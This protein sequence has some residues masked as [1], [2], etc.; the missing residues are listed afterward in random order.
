[1]RILV[2]C[3]ILLSMPSVLWATEK[4]HLLGGSF[5]FQ[6]V[7][8]YGPNY[9]SQNISDLAL[10]VEYSQ[11]SNS[12]V[13]YSARLGTQVSGDF[14]SM[15]LGVNYHFNP[16]RWDVNHPLDN[17]SIVTVSSWSPYLGVELSMSRLQISLKKTVSN[18]TDVVIAAQV[19][20]TL[21]GGVYYALSGD[22][23]IKGELQSSYLFSGEVASNSL[24][25]LCGISYF[26]KH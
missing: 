21:K 3:F 25:L 12:F 24:G 19:G 2:W 22:L 17:V 16:L 20:P 6:Q 1:M 26:F 15:G 8:A 5:G 9:E 11:L 18:D 14:F 7:Q 10:E 4:K 23:L 13:R